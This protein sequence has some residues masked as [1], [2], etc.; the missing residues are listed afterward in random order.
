MSEFF[1]FNL[2]RTERHN[3]RPLTINAQSEKLE[4]TNRWYKT[5]QP[6]R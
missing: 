4:Q 1:K 6:N 2:K 3:V 5:Q